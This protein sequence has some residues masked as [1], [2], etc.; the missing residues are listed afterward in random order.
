MSAL[1]ARFKVRGYVTRVKGWNI[2]MYSISTRLRVNDHRSVF[3]YL[4]IVV[5]EIWRHLATYDAAWQP[6]SLKLFCVIRRSFSRY[7]AYFLCFWYWCTHQIELESTMLTYFTFSLPF[8]WNEEGSIIVYGK[9]C[10]NRIHFKVSPYDA[11]NVPTY[12]N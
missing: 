11:S 12:L 5:F 4:N 6:R 8:S 1:H 3:F 2:N 7:G 9:S 10:W